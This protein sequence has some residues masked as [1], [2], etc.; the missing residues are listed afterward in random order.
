LKE[1]S[2]KG[3]TQSLECFL[4]DEQGKHVDIDLFILDQ[5]QYIDVAA[6]PTLIPRARA[7]ENQLRYFAVFFDNP[8]ERINLRLDHVGALWIAHSTPPSL[9][10]GRDRGDGEFQLDYQE[11]IPKKV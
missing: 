6:D 7:E 9:G 8:D 1:G 3:K 11:C 2:I 5:D 4:P 10:I